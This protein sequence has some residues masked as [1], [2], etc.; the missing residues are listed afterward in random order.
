AL[1]HTPALNSS[2]TARAGTTFTVDFELRKFNCPGMFKNF[3]IEVKKIDKSG[4]AAT[5]CEIQHENGK[6][7]SNPEHHCS[8]RNEPYKYQ[9]R[10]TA[11]K[12]DKDTKWMLYSDN[13]GIEKKEIAVNI[14]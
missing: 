4:T 1:L 7:S 10:D 2:V 14:L 13:D 12:S 3:Q 11:T 9:F 6:C 5:Y 8:C